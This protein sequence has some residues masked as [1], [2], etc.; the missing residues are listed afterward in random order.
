MAVIDPRLLPLI[1]VLAASGADW[2]AFELFDGLHVGQAPEDSDE[3]LNRARLAVREFRNDERLPEEPDLQTPTATP[4]VGDE[5]IEWAARYVAGRI[6][7]SIRMLEASLDH[8]ESI[9]SKDRDSGGTSDGMSIQ[10]QGGIALRMEG[11][12]VVVR[13]TQIDEGIAGLPVLKEALL[14]WAESVR[15]GGHTS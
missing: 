12:E 8:L 15:S 10:S 5:Q 11:E 1:E 2:L 14:N 13:R 9:V 4:I 7:D 3:E 6:S